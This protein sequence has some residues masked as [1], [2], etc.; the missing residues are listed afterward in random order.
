MNK[1]IISGYISKDI[2]PV[3]DSLK[4]ANAQIAVKRPYPFNK[5]SSGEYITD[6]LSIRFIGAR[7]IKTASQYLKKGDAV[8]ITG[9]VCKDVYKDKNDVWKEYNYIAVDTY[10]YQA[11]KKIE[12]NSISPKDSNIPIPDDLPESPDDFNNIPVNLAEDLPFKK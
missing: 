10:E 12:G 8:I 1:V 4:I 6:F 11:T 5:T 3:N 2:T 9:P 7:R